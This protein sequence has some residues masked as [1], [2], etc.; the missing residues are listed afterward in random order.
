[1]EWKVEWVATHLVYLVRQCMESAIHVLLLLAKRCI[2][3]IRVIH[4][5]YIHTHTIHTILPSAR[6][7]VTHACA[8]VRALGPPAH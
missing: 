7:W 4:R 6:R 8:A 5:I 2:H 1:M 3:I